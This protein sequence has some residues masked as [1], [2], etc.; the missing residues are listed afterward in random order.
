MQDIDR[1]RKA[2]EQ[3]IGRQMQTPKDFEFLSAC[4][5]QR[6][7]QT[8]SVSTLKR[9][10]GYTSSY[11]TTRTTTLDVLAR[12]VGYDNFE[13]FKQE[14]ENQSNRIIQ[15]T[16]NNQNTLNN[17][18][19]PKSSTRRWYIAVASLLVV[20]VLFFI[21]RAV[22]FSSEGDDREAT[23]PL[24][25]ISG[26]TFATPDDYLRLFGIIA[27]DDNYYDQPL[28]HRQGIIV[29]TP[30]FHHPRWHN[31]GN[32]DSLLPTITEYW[33]P[34][35]LVANSAQAEIVRQKNENLYFTVRRTNELR[36]TFMSGL[37][38]SAYVFL[39][40]YRADLT[41]SDSSHIV[42]QRI[43]DRLDLTHLDYL[44]QLR[45]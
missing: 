3:D 9:L 6:L 16:P 12:F 42:W 22:F 27:T 40:I 23:S 37:R 21:L 25:F 30:Q 29:W 43:A 39:G 35:T 20:A 1:L 28:P 2:I 34:D 24:T 45:N 33:S 10:W 17:P 38:D 7:Q 15:N 41:Q 11:A 36:I 19:T 44:E 4:I 14:V 31:D 18:T 26:Q 13:H 8:V 5:F 32:A